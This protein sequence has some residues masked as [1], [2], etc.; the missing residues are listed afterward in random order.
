[1]GDAAI[2]SPDDIDDRRLAI[3]NRAH[4]RHVLRYFRNRSTAGATLADLTEFLAE[5]DRRGLDDSGIE[6]RLHHV[7]LP[8]LDAAGFVEYDARSH[9]VRYRGDSV[10]ERWLDGVGEPSGT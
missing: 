2:Q 8:K 10:P 9:A 6:I 7:T 5:R 1:M 3:L 4:C